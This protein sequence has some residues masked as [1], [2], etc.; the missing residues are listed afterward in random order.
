M[1]GLEGDWKVL[2]MLTKNI[3][4]LTTYFML[5]RAISMA[6]WRLGSPAGSNLCLSAMDLST[7]WG[8]PVQI[9]MQVT[10]DWIQSIGYKLPDISPTR[11]PRPARI[12]TTPICPRGFWSNHS[13]MNSRAYCSIKSKRVG[14]MSRSVMDDERSRTRTRCRIMVRLMAE[15]GARSL[16]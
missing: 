16:E 7:S 6:F 5:P 10:E 1:S 12:P 11:S 8:F 4:N 15:A 3:R 9:K 13:V 2:N 14:R